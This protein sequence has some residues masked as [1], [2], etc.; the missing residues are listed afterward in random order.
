MNK[1]MIDLVVT[2]TIAICGLITGL[3]AVVA[4]IAKAIY[5]I[6]RPNRV[7]DERL[8]AIEKTLKEHETYLSRDSKRFDKLEDGNRIT[9]K[10]ILALLSHGIDGNE[11]EGMKKAKED[12]QNY[13]INQ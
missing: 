13:L 2:Q 12:L 3:G 9:Q 10:A 6:K 8:D 1:E 11:I 7:Q 4:L 5:S